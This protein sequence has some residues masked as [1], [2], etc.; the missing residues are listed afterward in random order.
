MRVLVKWLYSP[1]KKYGI[2][3]SSGVTSYIDRSLANRILKES[4]GMLIIVEVEEKPKPKQEK[5]HTRS[6]KKNE[7]KS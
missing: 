6:G 3:R 7:S 4:P 1:R 5:V 2:P